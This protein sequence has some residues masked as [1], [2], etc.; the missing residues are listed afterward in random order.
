MLKPL[1]FLLLAGGVGI[2][3]ATPMTA[4]LSLCNSG[5]CAIDGIDPGTVV[6]EVT[7][8]DVGG[9][10]DFTV[11][12]RNP[13]WLLWDGGLF[14]FNAPAGGTMV[15]PEGYSDAGSGNED[16]FGV[17]QYR[18]NGPTKGGLAA[19]GVT[20]FSFSVNGLQTSQIL[21]NADGHSF[22]AHIGV[23]DGTCNGGPCEAVTGFATDSVTHAPEPG[24]LMLLGSA[25]IGLGWISRR[26]RR[27]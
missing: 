5:L 2:A 20:V 23:P 16:G 18:I 11:T 17:F 14:G 10:I 12:T 19:N 8:T 1:V 4:E 25:L 21:P 6:A 15:L 3:L 9:G 13:D 26:E 24:T 22:A 7:A 27:G